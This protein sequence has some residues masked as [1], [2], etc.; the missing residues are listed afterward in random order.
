MKNKQTTTLTAS[1]TN[2][3]GPRRR[4]KRRD[5]TV[6]FGR[7]TTRPQTAQQR[8][9]V[10]K[11]RH[12]TKRLRFAERRGQGDSTDAVSSLHIPTPFSTTTTPVHHEASASSAP[13]WQTSARLS[14]RARC[15]HSA[16]TGHTA[17]DSPPV[18]CGQPRIRARSSL[19]SYGPSAGAEWARCAAPKATRRSDPLEANKQ[20][21]AQSQMRKRSTK[22]KISNKRNTIQKKR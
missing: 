5:P 12:V 1:Q 6:P 3:D 14:T 2:R 20:P 15:R 4:L 11:S 22:P 21:L 19:L 16:Q 17:D 7:K 18:P 9:D 10:F 8:Y 13:L